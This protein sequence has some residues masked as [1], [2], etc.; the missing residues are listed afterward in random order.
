[1]AAS[2]YA[3]QR[4]VTIHVRWKV[5]PYQ[6]LR[7][8]DGAGSDAAAGYAIPEPSA[9]DLSRGY[10]E[11]E[12]A[13]RLHVVSNTDWKIQVWIESSSGSQ[14]DVWI[15]R[16]GGTYAPVT[17]SPAV[18]ASGSHGTYD[19][20][21]DYRILLADGADAPAQEALDIVYT[22]MSD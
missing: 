9:L 10:I 15:R 13:V 11:D 7:L 12:N 3:V 19:I 18:L 20:G 8:V 21:V 5:L 16:H 22:I 4:S 14:G 1:M 6:T 2:A 17:G